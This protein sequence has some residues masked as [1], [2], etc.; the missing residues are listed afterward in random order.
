M[1]ERVERLKLL[2]FFK[3]WKGILLCFL[4]LHKRKARPL[5]QFQA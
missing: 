3:A 2:N 5:L 4:Q 1:K